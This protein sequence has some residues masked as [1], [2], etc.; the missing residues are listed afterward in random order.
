MMMNSLDRVRH[1][2]ADWCEELAYRVNPHP[3]NPTDPPERGI[4]AA[5]RGD[6]L[7]FDWE[8]PHGEVPT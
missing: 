5:D 6:A 3:S 1:W 2:L 4:P 8:E 7:D